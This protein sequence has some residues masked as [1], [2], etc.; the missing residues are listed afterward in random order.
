MQLQHQGAEFVDGRIRPG[1]RINDLALYIGEQ[2]TAPFVEARTDAFK[3]PE[4]RMDRGSPQWP[5]SLATM[6]P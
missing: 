2:L 3:M 5:V 4:E 1:R 6:S